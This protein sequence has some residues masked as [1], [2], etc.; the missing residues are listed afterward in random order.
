MASQS[1][2]WIPLGGLGEVGKNMMAFEYGKNILIVDTGVMFPESDMFGIDAVIPGRWA[3]PPAPA[4]ITRRPRSTAVVA[5]SIIH[6]GVRWA[7]TIRTSNGTE[8]SSSTSTAACITARSE[9]LP[10]M[11]PTSGVP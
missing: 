7:D 6:S 4:T 11:T 10:M 9:S 8:N 1:L 3:A 2:K 5:Y